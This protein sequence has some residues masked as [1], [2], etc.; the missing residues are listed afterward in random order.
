MISLRFAAAGDFLRAK[1]GA[2]TEL[3]R[4]VGGNIATATQNL[5]ERR[6]VRRQIARKC[7]Q[8]VAR[9]APA[10]LREFGVQLLL[11]IHALFYEARRKASTEPRQK[12]VQTPHGPGG[13]GRKSWNR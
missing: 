8:R 5:R 11:Q 3:M 6:V 13:V 9:I 2:A 4:H 10:P 1:T 12:V 7:P